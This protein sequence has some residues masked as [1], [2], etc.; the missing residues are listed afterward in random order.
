L[1][2]RGTKLSAHHPSAKPLSDAARAKGQARSA[3]VNREKALADDANVLPV[4]RSMR[5][6][7]SSLAAVAAHL[8]AEGYVTRNGA[9][10]SAVQVMRVLKRAA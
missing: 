6:A 8:N 10:W 9:A 7:G 3:R 2:A 1:K 5:T 4:A